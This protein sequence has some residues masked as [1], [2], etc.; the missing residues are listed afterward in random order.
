VQPT[1]ASAHKRV[2]PRSRIFPSI[3]VLLRCAYF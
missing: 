1:S 2:T 3:E